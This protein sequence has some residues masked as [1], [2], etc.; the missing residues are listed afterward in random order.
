MKRQEEINPP[1]T[2][3]RLAITVVIFYLIPLLLLSLL[4]QELMPQ[5]STWMLFS[6]G[7]V[8]SLVGSIILFTCIYRW[9]L[10]LF[11]DLKK[12]FE[13]RNPK[14][15]LLPKIEVPQEPKIDSAMQERFIAEAVSAWQSK[16][17]Q[18]GSELEEKEITMQKLMNEKE[19]A[20]HELQAIVHQFTSFQQGVQ[21][22]IE[23]KDRLI[24]QNQQAV[25]EQRALIEKHQ[26]HISLLESKEKDLS[27]EIKTLLQLSSLENILNDKPVEKPQN[28]KLHTSEFLSY[29]TE[30][31]FQVEEEH[32]NAYRTSERASFHV[33][34]IDTPES[35][36]AQL[37][38]C[39]DVATK[40]SGANY[41]IGGA[42]KIHNLS[43]D[44]QAL[45]LRRLCDALNSENSVAILLY[46][47][48]EGKLLYANDYARNILGWGLDKFTESFSEIV[49]SGFEDWK[50]GLNQ[51]AT[52]YSAVFP[53]TLRS[54]AGPEMTMQCHL[55]AVP[56]GT[57]RHHVI[58]VL[59]ESPKKSP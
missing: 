21:L 29:T 14:V 41:I 47:Q 15:A 13:E 7:L 3:I 37:K 22:Q 16:N 31:D 35:A 9:E 4:G 28:K 5:S 52:E 55:G 12:F 56:A 30:N 33:K 59:Y 23:Q 11:Y 58:G 8:M 54:K 48:K 42:S 49:A 51:L 45:D 32:P 40:M 2:R 17:V 36:L 25:A 19:E 53:M 24:A 50:K 34:R 6:V 20:Q 18:L 27:Y 43:L 26:Q 38:H 39:V 46:S 44:N 10:S 1:Q 57:F